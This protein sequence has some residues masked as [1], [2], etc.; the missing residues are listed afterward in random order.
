MKRILMSIFLIGLFAMGWSTPP[1]DLVKQS[2]QSGYV[3]AGD[4]VQADVIYAFDATVLP[5]PDTP[6]PI[7]WLDENL[8]QTISG[9][10]L[11]LY[12]FLALKMPTS[13]SISI[14]ANLYKLSTWF[15]PD[16]SNKGGKFSIINKS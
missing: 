2:Q 9:V 16:K 12:E 14:L 15:V 11:L 1:P 10:I 4:Q 6:A 13:K 5:A 3:N 7:K 8:L